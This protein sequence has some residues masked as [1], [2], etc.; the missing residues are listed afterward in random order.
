MAL[1]DGQ[2]LVPTRALALLLRG[3][4]GTSQ[5]PRQ[6]PLVVEEY[7][8]GQVAV[9]FDAVPDGFGG[10]AGGVLPQ[11][12]HAGSLLACLIRGA[13]SGVIAGCLVIGRGFVSAGGA[14]AQVRPARDLP[15]VA[16]LEEE[17]A[18]EPRDAGVR[19]RAGH[20]VAPTRRRPRRRGAVA[21][22]AFFRGG[23]SHVSSPE[24]GIEFGQ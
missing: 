17:A 5:Q 2:V 10:G 6:G 14:G 15:A 20:D 12:G 4:T 19:R 18:E 24:R 9:H 11:E 21:R 7:T 3:P 1:Q 23:V 13:A 22:A 8:V 16:V